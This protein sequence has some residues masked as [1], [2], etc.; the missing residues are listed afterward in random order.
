M[1][2]TVSDCDQIGSGRPPFETEG[3]SPEKLLSGGG[4]GAV[5]RLSGIQQLISAQKHGMEY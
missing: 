4:G 5:F 2:P 1:V 3:I